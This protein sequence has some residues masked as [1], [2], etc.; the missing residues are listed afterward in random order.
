MVE[1]S[2]D[3]Q[4]KLNALIC[5]ELYWHDLAKQMLDRCAHRRL[6]K[7]VDDDYPSDGCTVVH[8][9]HRQHDGINLIRRDR[10]PKIPPPPRDA[11]HCVLEIGRAP[12]SPCLKVLAALEDA[13]ASFQTDGSRIKGT[14]RL[15]LHGAHA[16]R[17]VLPRIDEFQALYPDVEI[18]VSTGDVW[19]TWSPRPST[20]S[21]GLE[22]GKATPRPQALGAIA[23]LRRIGK[24]EVAVR[25]AALKA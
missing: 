1:L 4:V 6:S 11:P 14:L 2:R 23:D 7:S 15:D 24:R 9:I 3:R 19:S 20:A 12:S 16:T 13:A 5:V 10:M 22:S 8:D 21:F 17:I 25:L 18:R